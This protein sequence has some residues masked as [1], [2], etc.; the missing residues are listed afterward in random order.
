MRRFAGKLYYSGPGSDYL[1]V[2]TFII[3]GDEIAFSLASVTQEYGCWVADSTQT[4]ILNHSNGTYL[5]KNVNA[6]Q[7]GIS[8]SSPWNIAFTIKDGEDEKYIEVE[9]V[10]IEE[11]I[12]Y[13]FDGELEAV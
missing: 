11:G 7:Q 9:G 1:D 3:R 6:T 8:L 4:A 2:T 12:A 13:N 10:L 5:A